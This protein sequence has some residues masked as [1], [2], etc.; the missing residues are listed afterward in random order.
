MRSDNARPLDQHPQ[1][2]SM[3]SGDQRITRGSGE[4]PS[5][6]ATMELT[7][8]RFAS[9]ARATLVEVLYPKVCPGCGLRG[10]W[11]CENCKTTVPQLLFNIC[12]SCGSPNNTPH[13]CDGLGP[14]V[15]KARAVYPY[16]GWVGASIRR[17]KYGAEPTRAED[18][19]A[20]MIP[21][22]AA[23]GR[24]DVVVPV[25]LHPKKLNLRG[26]NQ[27]EL[28][29]RRIALHADLPMTSLLIRTRATQPQVQLDR[30]NR[31][32]NVADAF[33]LDPMRAIAPGKRILVIDDVRTTGATTNAC[34]TVLKLKAKA[35]SVSVLTFAQEISNAELQRWMHSLTASPSRQ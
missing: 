28:L 5:H 10:M 32:A 1:A 21:L 14:Q 19:A 20:C 12:E 13:H 6:R 27:S 29:A 23:F 16:T 24:I 31:H 33:A 15:A 2:E 30:E 35:E 17:F 11:L 18:L 26:Y 25:P 22:L 3:S 34:A 9:I 8:R 4:A 7:V